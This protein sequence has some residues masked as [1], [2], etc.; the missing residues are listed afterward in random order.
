MCVRVVG[1]I[2]LEK[3][4][5]HP[6]RW[7]IKHLLKLFQLPFNDIN[8]ML[9]DFVISYHTNRQGRRASNVPTNAGHG[10]ETG[11]Y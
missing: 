6:P 1:V 2:F 9:I 3:T 7:K 5:S 11:E 4:L 8:I 10:T